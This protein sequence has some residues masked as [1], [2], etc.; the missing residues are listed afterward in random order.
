ME[1]I[2]LDMIRAAEKEENYDLISYVKRIIDQ[3][4]L[5]ANAPSN[6]RDIGNTLLKTYDCG[7]WVYEELELWNY[8]D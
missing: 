8:E 1:K 4:A 7:S 6:W 2:I 3:F 5:T